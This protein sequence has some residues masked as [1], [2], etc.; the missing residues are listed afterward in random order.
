MMM[1]RVYGDIDMIEIFK[2]I[3]QFVK[4]DFKTSGGVM[5]LSEE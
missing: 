1:S 2:V 4:S 3:A 5:T